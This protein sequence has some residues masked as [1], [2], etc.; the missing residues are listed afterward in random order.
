[1]TKSVETLDRL[2][3]VVSKAA[4]AYLVLAIAIGLVT[5]GLLLGL[6]LIPQLE[7]VGAIGSAATATITLASV[8][9]MASE[10]AWLGALQA[11]KERVLRVNSTPADRH[12]SRVPSPPPSKE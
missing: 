8:A 11:G 4:K 10:R 12:E 2:I 3:A 7:V 1:M 6:V 5:V 9:L